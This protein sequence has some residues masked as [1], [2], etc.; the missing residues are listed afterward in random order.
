MCK[1][2]VEFFSS[3]LSSRRAWAP[4]E[5]KLWNRKWKDNYTLSTYAENFSVVSLLLFDKKSGK[6]TPP[7]TGKMAISQNRKWRHQNK[8]KVSQ[9]FMIYYQS[10]K[11]H[12]NRLN[13]FREIGCTKSVRKIKIP[14]T[15]IN[16]NHIVSNLLSFIYAF[17]KW[18]RLTCERFLL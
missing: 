7:K 11:F 18:T 2:F 13:S 15:I 14:K 5:L 9:I 1:N 16:S 6:R 3:I 8:K 17:W 4:L 12:G 10:W